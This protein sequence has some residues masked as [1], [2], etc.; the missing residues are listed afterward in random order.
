MDKVVSGEILEVIEPAQ[1]EEP[2]TSSLITRYLVHGSNNLAWKVDEEE[3][4][5][6]LLDWVKDDRVK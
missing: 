4:S 2:L 1:L 6:C 3:Y 5:D